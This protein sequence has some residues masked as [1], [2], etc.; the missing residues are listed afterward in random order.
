MNRQYTT[1]CINYS[2]PIRD[3]QPECR[4]HLLVIDGACCICLLKG[5]PKH[6]CACLNAR[7]DVY[8]SYLHDTSTC[9]ASTFQ[10]HVFRGYTEDVYLIMKL[11]EQV[12]PY[13]ETQ[14]F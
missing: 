8:A 11:A 1:E 4:G 12:T 10:R 2:H 9:H 5:C 14:N 13:F 7:R 3:K 6:C